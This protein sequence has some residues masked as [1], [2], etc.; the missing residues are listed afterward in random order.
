MWSN[1]PNR[2]EDEKDLVTKVIHADDDPSLN[3]WT[4]RMWFIG[5]GLGIFGAIMETIY[6]FRP[7]TLDVSNIFLALLSYIFGT[8]LEWVIPKTGFIGRWFNPHPF[9]MKEHAAMV[10]IASSG[11]QTALAVEVIAVQRLFYDRAPNVLISILLVVSSQC[12]GYGFA[13]LL[14]RVLVYPT[15]M[16]W[17]S[18]LPMNTLL[19]TLHRD[20]RETRNRLRFFWWILIAAFVWE[21]LPEYVMP[22]LTGVSVFCL[23]KQD[24]MVFTNIFGGSNGN[25]GLGVLSL[26]LDWQFISSKPLWMPL[27]TLTNSLA[28]YIICIFLFLGVYYGNVW[29]ARDFPF[30]SQLLFSQNSTSSN[31]V[32]Y[33]QTEILNDENVLLPSAL[34]TEGIPFFAGTYAMF[35]F[36][37]NLAVTATV[38][39]LL[40]WNWDDLKT[41]YSFLSPSSI[42]QLLSP[43][44]WNLRFWQSR[45][46]GSRDIDKEKDPHYQL[47]LAYPE[48]PSWWYACILILSVIMGL[49]AIYAA[50]ST[51]PWYGFFTSL[52]VAGTFILFFGAQVALTGYQGNVQPI[53]QMIG[54][55]LHPGQPLANMYF[56][57]FGYNSVIQGISMVQDLK[58]GQY[59]K[60]PPRATFCAQVVGTLVG[61]VVNYIMMVEITTN[62]RDILL[63][64]QGTN[65]WSGQNIQQFNSQAIAWGALAK[66]MFSPGSRYGLVPIGLLLGFLP[67]LI[68][69]TLHRAYPRI[70]F[71]KVN[72]PIIL[73]YVGI[74]SVGISSS[75][76]SY[77]AIGFASQFWLRRWKPDWFIKYNYVLAAALDG[78]TQI[79]VFLLTYTVLG[80]VGPEIKFPKYWGNNADG[81]FDYCMRD[82]GAGSVAAGPI[83][84]DG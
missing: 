76:L 28:G 35:L 64:I 15:K 8:F 36:T 2:I 9:N 71:S 84:L 45:V 18:L 24:S 21:V 51:L 37:T 47:M 67:P 33:N 34:E 3:P 23:A 52:G 22:I 83:D 42:R 46:N 1:G 80:G 72:T 11:A 73:A 58:F 12:V 68:F 48:C 25:E 77:F 14:R 27:A 40:L 29:Q 10:V 38:S 50:K 81:N 16:V 63:S 6:F 13:G 62:Q 49:V 59:A 79:L 74:L 43:R 56:T 26:G 20:R 53:V 57:L 44:S 78:G 7:V 19:E 70:G 65:I 41:G 75:M 17:P 4:F 39:H 60:L 69:H 66:E 31:Y 5:I 54:G 32:V 82:P 30:L 55:Y 61:A